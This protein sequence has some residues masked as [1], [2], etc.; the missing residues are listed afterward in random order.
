VPAILIGAL[1][2]C[3]ISSW[4][5]QNYFRWKWFS[6]RI[7]LSTNY[8]FTLLLPDLRTCLGTVRERIRSV[9][10]VA[11]TEPQFSF[12]TRGVIC[13]FQGRLPMLVVY[14]I[15]V[16]Y[17]ELHPVAF[18]AKKCYIEWRGSRLDFLSS[19]RI[20]FMSLSVL[21]TLLCALN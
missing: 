19:I 12:F 4:I 15:C 3:Y 9:C 7:L 20:N 16:N 18:L 10:L 11:V 21:I 8:I 17:S 6:F 14:H 13:L 1:V 2:S 5:C